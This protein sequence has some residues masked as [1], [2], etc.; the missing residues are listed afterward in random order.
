DVYLSNKDEDFTIKFVEKVNDMDFGWQSVLYN[1]FQY[2]IE[3]AEKNDDYEN[4]GFAKVSYL[5]K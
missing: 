2:L 3:K 1:I 4:K 5:L